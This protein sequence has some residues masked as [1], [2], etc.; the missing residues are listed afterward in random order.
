MPRLREKYERE[1]V[2]MLM[3]K[4]GIKNRMAV[5]RL[6][7]VGINMGLRKEKES[8]EFLNEV[9]GHLAALAGQRPVVTKARQSIAGFKVREGD[10]VGLKVTLRRDRMWEFLD[11]MIALALPRVRDFRGLSRKSFD[12]RGNYTLGIGEQ[13]VFPE[14]DSDSVNNSQGMDVSIVTTAGDDAK[15]EALLHALGM[16]FQNA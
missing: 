8:K 13:T 7:K 16:P 11:R 1:V 5:P 10:K 3:E 2:P 4:F 9:L 15:A 14:V 6:T 12:G